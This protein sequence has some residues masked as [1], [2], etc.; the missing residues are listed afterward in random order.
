MYW[1]V[2]HVS[3]SGQKPDESA[4]PC[5]KDHHPEHDRNWSRSLHEGSTVNFP[6]CFCSCQT[7]CSRQGSGGALASLRDSSF[8]GGIDAV[9]GGIS[10]IFLTGICCILSPVS[11]AWA[12]F[13]PLQNAHWSQW[14][15]Y[16]RGN[17]KW[18]WAYGNNRETTVSPVKKLW[19]EIHLTVFH[20]NAETA[21]MVMLLDLLWWVRICLQV[22]Q[23]E[24]AG[25]PV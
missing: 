6:V 2:H 24:K 15:F 19:L 20:D 9:P 16:I 10:H 23:F 4:K 7:L 3:S 8:S 21:D 12:N 11:V 17:W 18:T 5:S 14:C 22:Q 13:T 25:F 1:Y